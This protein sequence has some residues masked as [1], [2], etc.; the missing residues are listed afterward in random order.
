MTLVQLEYVVALDNFR[1]F[2]EAAAHCKVT[3]P[4]LSMQIQ[5]IEQDLGVVLFDRSKQPIYPTQIGKEVVE[6]AR[7]ILEMADYMHILVHSKKDVVEGELK[8]GVIPTL[9]SNLL[10]LFIN[11]FVS[12]YPDVQIIV[13]ELKTEDLLRDLGK[14]KVDVALMVHSA[15]ANQGY[16]YNILPLFYEG[17]AVYFSKDH[18]M[19]EEKEL[20]EDLLKDRNLNVWFLEDGHCF[21]T[22]FFDFCRL[23]NDFYLHQSFRYQSGYI[24][25]LKRLVDGNTNSLTILPELFVKTLSEA[26]MSRVRF[27]KKPEPV[28]EIALV[29]RRNF[30]K[31]RLIDALKDEILKS[32]PKTCH[33]LDNKIIISI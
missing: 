15:D 5:K 10:P 23:K 25:T 20:S 28:R 11:N 18:P 24:E 13:N 32:I 22:Q 16:N 7:K 12:Q 27:F 8:I 4:T 14:D 1:N 3:Q 26:D 6:Q 33:T 9:G 29:T 21:K 2:S 19:L 31:K 17:F 30:L